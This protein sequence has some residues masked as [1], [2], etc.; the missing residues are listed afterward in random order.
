M[1]KIKE[2]K[3]DQKK[4]NKHTPEGMELIKKSLKQ[5]GAGRSIVLDRNNNI[6]AGNG[7]VEAAGN[8]GMDEVQIVESDGTKIIAVKRTDIDIDS[9]QGRELALADNSTA[10]AD[11][12]WDFDAIEDVEQEWGIDCDE[13]GV[14]NEEKMPTNIDAQ[15]LLQKDYVMTITFADEEGIKTFVENYKEIIKEH[16]AYYSVKGGTL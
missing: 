9:K 15:E 13:W 2:L 7:V 3:F 10:A 5:L 4:F 16:G 6:I 1:A 14:E 11:L 8:I 12:Q